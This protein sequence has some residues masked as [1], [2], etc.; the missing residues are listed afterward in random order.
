MTS[1]RERLLAEQNPSSTATSAT[2]TSKRTS[3]FAA[4]RLNMVLFSVMGV[5]VVNWAWGQFALVGWAALCL[6]AAGAKSKGYPMNR[7]TI[8]EI[9]Q[10]AV[11][12]VL[13]FGLLTEGRG[14]SSAPTALDC[15]SGVLGC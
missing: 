13:L 3:V 9:V 10:A 7:G 8:F 14:C 4:E 2:S 6:F 15:L 11:I 12:V 5:S 1:V